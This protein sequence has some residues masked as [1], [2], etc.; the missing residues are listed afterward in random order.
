VQQQQQQQPAAAASSARGGAAAADYQK[1][2]RVPRL[3]L[4][5]ILYS[6]I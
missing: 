3:D 1:A 2:K 5:V 6:F 4:S